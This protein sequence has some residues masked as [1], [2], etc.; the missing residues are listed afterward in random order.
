MSLTNKDKFWKQ[1]RA[2]RRAR[3]KKSKHKLALANSS[4]ANPSRPALPLFFCTGFSPLTPLVWSEAE[5]SVRASGE[6]CRLGPDWRLPLFFKLGGCFHCRSHVHG[7]DPQR[8]TEIIKQRVWKGRGKS[9]D[10]CVS[11]AFEKVSPSSCCWWGGWRWSSAIRVQKAKAFTHMWKAQRFLWTVACIIKE[12]T[13]ATNGLSSNAASKLSDDF[14]WRKANWPIHASL[15][16]TARVKQ[17]LCFQATRP[18]FTSPTNWQIRWTLDVTKGPLQMPQ[19]WLKFAEMNKENSN[20]I[21]NLISYLKNWNL[22]LFHNMA[23]RDS[24]EQ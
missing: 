1:T 17:R 11:E 12:E 14:R 8:E 3:T 9:F 15:L 20:V 10:V 19:Q 13:G 5:S 2:A 22:Y 6:R 4:S 23:I 18:R 24:S 7:E 16:V 21:S